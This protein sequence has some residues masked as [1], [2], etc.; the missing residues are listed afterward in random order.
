MREEIKNRLKVEKVRPIL[1][2]Q[3]KKFVEDKKNRIEVVEKVREQDRRGRIVR[4]KHRMR[5]ISK[6]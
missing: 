1:D 6:G 5:K 4:N 2:R 3:R